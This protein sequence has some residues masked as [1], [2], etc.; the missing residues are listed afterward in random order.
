[1][2]GAVV[3]VRGREEERK[4]IRR[5]PRR[6]DEARA[7]GWVAG[8]AATLSPVGEPATSWMPGGGGDCGG[9]G[10]GDRGWSSVDGGGEGW[11]LVDGGGK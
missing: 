6:A 9:S 1:M 4:Q 8:F 2:T 7:V 10:E 11:R 3:L 5:E